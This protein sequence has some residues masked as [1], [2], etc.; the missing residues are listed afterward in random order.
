[1]LNVSVN[2]INLPA[3]DAVSSAGQVFRGVAPSASAT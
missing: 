1:V 3:L 2:G